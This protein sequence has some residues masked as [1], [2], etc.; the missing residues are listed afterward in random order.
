MDHTEAT[1]GWA[2]ENHSLYRVRDNMLLLSLPSNTSSVRR[3]TGKLLPSAVM[4]GGKLVSPRGSMLSSKK[5]S[6]PGHSLQD[7]G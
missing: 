4:P 1:K 7:A 2:N 3:S 5:S 6:G